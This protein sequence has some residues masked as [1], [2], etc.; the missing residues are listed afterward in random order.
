MIIFLI[1]NFNYQLRLYTELISL[2][3][4]GTYVTHYII[5]YNT[6]HCHHYVKVGILCG[7]KSYPNQLE[8]I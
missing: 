4:D 6:L 1:Y 7:M 5:M 8:Y 3:L 2:L